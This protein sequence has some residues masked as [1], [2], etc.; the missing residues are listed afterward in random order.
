VQD[1]QEELNQRKEHEKTI[2]SDNQQMT[3][4]LGE[5]KIQLEKIMYENKEGMITADSLKESNQELSEELDRLRQALTKLQQQQHENT[6]NHGIK[7]SKLPPTP[8]KQVDES[9]SNVKVPFTKKRC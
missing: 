3:S 1:L 7:D 2:V 9:V 4:E 8:A 6:A 5:A